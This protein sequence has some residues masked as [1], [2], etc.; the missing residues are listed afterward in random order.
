MMELGERYTV[1]E[2][3]K[4][5]TRLEAKVLRGSGMKGSVLKW[6]ENEMG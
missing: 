1:G 6:G 5:V 3:K 2:R 4:I